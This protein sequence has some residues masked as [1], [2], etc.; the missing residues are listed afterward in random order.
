MARHNLTF[1]PFYPFPATA[2]GLF[3]DVP[4]DNGG[5]SALSAV[6]LAR[7]PSQVVR[8][9]N[10]PTLNRPQGPS[11][12]Q[13][14]PP[15]LLLPCCCC[16]LAAAVAVACSVVSVLSLLL[17]LLLLLLFF[18]NVA[19]HLLAVV[20][21]L[22][23]SLFRRKLMLSLRYFDGRLPSSLHPRVCLVASEF[24]FCPGRRRA[25][26]R[27]RTAFDEPGAA[28][29]KTG[30]TDQP[31]AAYDDGDDDDDEPGNSEPDISGAIF[32]CRL[33]LRHLRGS[34]RR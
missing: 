26:Q 4:T 25:R 23:L 34:P 9:L 2:P 1:P 31:V 13:W 7:T 15:R 14:V 32:V 10:H 24:S 28:Q 21:L 29:G 6:D 33:W 19:V 16:C 3:Q 5:D 17:L 8:P 18:F 12:A 27:I 22:L 30:S 11:G 20:H